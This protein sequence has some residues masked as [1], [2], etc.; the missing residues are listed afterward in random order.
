MGMKKNFRQLVAAMLTMAGAGVAQAGEN[1]IPL[2]PDQ[3]MYDFQLFA[4]PDLREYSMWADDGDGIY[5]NYDRLYWGITVPRTVGVATTPTGQNIIPSQPV[6]PFTIANLNYDYL[7]FAESNPILVQQVVNG[8]ATAD[9]IENISANTTLFEV[10]S[11]PLRLDLNTSWLRTK[12]TWGNRYEGG[13]SYDGRG[14]NISYLQ[15]GKQEQSFG[16]TNE[17]A[18]SSPTQDFTFTNNSSGGGGGGGGGAGTGGSTVLNISLETT[19]DSPPP[20]HTITQNLLQ[21]NSTELQSGAV[22]M[23]LRRSLGKRRGATDA[24]FSLGPRF[25]Q[26]AERYELDYT[27]FQNSFNNGNAGGGG[28]GGGGVGGGG[29]NNNQNNNQ[30]GNNNNQNNNQ[31]G[32]NNQNNNNQNNNTITGAAGNV[33]YAADLRGANAVGITTGNLPSTL[34]GVGAGSLFQV[35]A[36][37]TY[38]SNNLVGPEFGLMFEGSKG[39]WDW[40]AGGSFTAGFNWQNNIY[41]GSNLPQDVGADYLRTNFAG[42]GVTSVGYSAPSNGPS[43]LNVVSVPTSPLITQIFAT[44]QNNATNSADHRFV[45]SPVG[46]WRFGGRFK[47]SQAISLNIGY[48]GMWL[49]QLA[50]AST[51]T[52]FQTVSRLTAEAAS[53]RTAIV[54]GGTIVDPGQTA[55]VNADNIVMEYVPNNPKREL[56]SGWRYVPP[57]T[58]VATSTVPNPEQFVQFNNTIYTQ[59][60]GLGGG[61]EYVFTNG[62]D[63][64]IEIKY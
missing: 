34:T 64:G 48:T 32:N 15:V 5:F 16:T 8:T 50:R 7:K 51:N 52:G 1:W 22:A 29:N 49:S 28:G 46:E 56:P 44:G 36:W 45:F 25:I 14:V 23:T 3:D 43:T 6:S 4:P 59:Q 58:T 55:V 19:T 42:G 57:T 53:N 13:W 62:I 31:G 30:G 12:M 9:S 37:D 11:S 41:R 20:D 60:V 38:T 18:V 10:G 26:F 47:V 17:F 39:R 2:L 33:Q 63:F 40:Y 35:A 24:T 21:R 54:N 61:N 27:S